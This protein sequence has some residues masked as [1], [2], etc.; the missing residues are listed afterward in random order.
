MDKQ[1]GISHSDNIAGAVAARWLRLGPEA[2]ENTGVMAPRVCAVIGKG[3]IRELYVF[4][5]DCLER[6]E[7][8]LW[9]SGVSRCGF[10]RRAG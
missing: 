7:V 3:S 10:R 5:I 2:R 8:G 4:V 6:Q 9:T 1:E